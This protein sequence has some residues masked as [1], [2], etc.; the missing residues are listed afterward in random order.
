MFPRS[1]RGQAFHYLDFSDL[2]SFMDFADKTKVF[3]LQTIFQVLPLWTASLGQGTLVIQTQVILKPQ[4]QNRQ[5][6]NPQTPGGMKGIH[7]VGEKNQEQTLSAVKNNQ[8]I[9]IISS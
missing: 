3:K 1:Y 9:A 8:T 4:T 2:L 5:N 7:S 6:I